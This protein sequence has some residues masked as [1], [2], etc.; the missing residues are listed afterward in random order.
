MKIFGIK[1]YRHPLLFFLAIIMA[2]TALAVVAYLLTF[3]V[4]HLNTAL[5]VKIEP[6]KVTQF[7]IDG[8]EKLNLIKK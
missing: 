5:N 1:N 8:F 4:K 2:I 3:L 6:T 7:D